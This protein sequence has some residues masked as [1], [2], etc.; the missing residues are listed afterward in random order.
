MIVIRAISD[1]ESWVFSLFKYLWSNI[2]HSNSDGDNYDDDDDDA[3][4]AIIFSVDLYVN[5][6]IIGNF[7]LC[8]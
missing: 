5:K 2:I 4:S 1:W 7:F 3:G 6:A 8:D